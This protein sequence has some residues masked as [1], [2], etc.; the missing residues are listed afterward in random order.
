MTREEKMNA[1]LMYF[2]ELSEKLKDTHEVIR[3]CNGD[4]SAYLIPKGSIEELSYY[5][6]PADS[7]RVSDHWNWFA[8]T[9]KCENAKYIQ[10]LSVDLPWARRREVDGKATRP[11]IGYQVAYFGSDKKYHHVFGEK[12]NRRTKE[13]SW[14][15][16]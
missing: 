2:E 11:V 15:E 13:W 10:C 6:K 4:A 8:S 9:K 16:S 3:S 5:S 1:C 14:E 12:F 7:Y